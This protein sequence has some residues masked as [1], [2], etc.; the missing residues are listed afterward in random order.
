MVRY[1]L[2]LGADPL[3][4]YHDALAPIRPRRQDGFS[5]IE[6]AWDSYTIGLPSQQRVA[7]FKI[8]DL[9]AAG[10]S[11]TRFDAQSLA[12]D[13]DALLAQITDPSAQLLRAAEWGFYDTVGA[14]LDARAVRDSAVLTEAT[15]SAIDTGWDDIARLLLT[16]GARPGGGPLHMAVR[17]SSPGLVRH[18]LE[19]GAD[20]N[21]LVNGFSAA[22]YWWQE[23]PAAPDAG[24]RPRAGGDRLVLYELIVHGAEVCWL[25]EHRQ[26]MAELNGF[27]LVVLLNTASECWPDQ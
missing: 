18:L 17:R 16:R 23:H 9:L 3:E 4:Q 21:E 27:S 11:S 14:L 8:H 26:K 24:P 5:A 2:R 25:G 10:A 15:V 7:G 22:H 6:F 12:V 19:L 20:P 1:L 13:G